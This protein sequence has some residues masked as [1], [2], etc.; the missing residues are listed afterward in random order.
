MLEA[1]ILSAADRQSGL[2]NLH[3]QV[4]HKSGCFGTRHEHLRAKPF[5]MP[6][7]D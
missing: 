4:G 3:Q 1:D 7:Q 5:R 6:D 2:Q